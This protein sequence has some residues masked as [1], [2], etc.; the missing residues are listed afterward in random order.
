M[1]G[2]QLEMLCDPSFR[3]RETDEKVTDWLLQFTRLTTNYLPQTPLVLGIYRWHSLARD[4]AAAVSRIQRRQFH[5]CGVTY[6]RLLRGVYG[7]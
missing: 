3:I 2:V 7:V 4:R 1:V 5:A 6:V